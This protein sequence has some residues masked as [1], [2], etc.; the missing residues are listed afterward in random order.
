MLTLMPERLHHDARRFQRA[1]HR[2]GVGHRLRVVAVQ[3]EGVRLER[4]HVPVERR[5]RA[6]RARSITAWAA[7]RAGSVSTAPGSRRDCKVPAAV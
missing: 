5:S 1:A 7:A 4:D 2:G 3:A 6:R